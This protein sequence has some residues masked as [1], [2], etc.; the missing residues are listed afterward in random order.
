MYDEAAELGDEIDKLRHTISSAGHDLNELRHSEQQLLADMAD[1]RRAQLHL[2]DV[3]LLS[4]SSIREERGAEIDR[5]VDDMSVRTVADER[6][7]VAEKDR[8]RIDRSQL[9]RESTVLEEEAGNIDRAIQQ[10][11]EE[12]N[13]AKQQV[14]AKLECLR[15]EIAE[16][17]KLL[18]I[19]RAEERVLMDTQEG[20]VLQIEEVR[21][22]FDRQV[23]RI[24]EWRSSIEAMRQA[25]EEE[26]A[27]VAAIEA[28][29]ISRCKYLESLHAERENVANDMDSEVSLIRWTIEQILAIEQLTG[30]AAHDDGAHNELNG[31]EGG[32]GFSELATL[33]ESIRTLTAQIATGKK[34]RELLSANLA[35]YTRE[36]RDIEDRMP[37]ME[38]EKKSFAASRQFREAAAV[39]SL[40]KDA[41]ARKECLLQL[42]ESTSSTLVS[43]SNEIVQQEQTLMSLSQEFDSLKKSKALKKIASI[44]R[45]IRSIERDC[46]TLIHKLSP[47]YASDIAT[48]C[49]LIIDTALAEL[50]ANLDSIKRN[51]GCSQAEH[52]E[53]AITNNDDVATEDAQHTDDASSGAEGNVDALSSDINVT[54]STSTAPVAVGISD[55]TPTETLIA[56][57]HTEHSGEPPSTVPYDEFI[58]KITGLQSTLATLAGEVDAAVEDEDYERAAALDDEKRAIQAEIKKIQEKL[59]GLGIE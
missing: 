55:D 17:E 59:L 2:L 39:A 46:A 38:L 48:L 31:S 1:N 50:A 56:D 8:L 3:I 19:K 30:P 45:N 32:G 13:A 23:Q 16:L 14:D 34:A 33:E 51:T 15:G 4:T 40:V 7:L 57:V 5:L 47:S 26:E 52:D 27:K 49:R 20:A 42:M 29:W 37:R 11:C 36:V 18:A 35:D 21:R 12:A 41:A 10:Q 28:E 54:R 44:E 53:V 58:S 25:C 24:R 9:E 43:S 22:K 6:E